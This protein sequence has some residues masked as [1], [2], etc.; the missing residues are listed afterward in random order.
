MK[1]N[2]FSLNII[3]Y[4]PIKHQLS[5][6]S[7]LKLPT[8]SC[9]PQKLTSSLPKHDIFIR[10]YSSEKLRTLKGYGLRRT[11]CYKTI[12]INPP[13]PSFTIFVSDNCNF[14]RAF[15]GIR[16]ILA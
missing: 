7:S 3:Q 11:L 5:E 14:S 15:S 8:N 2:P 12:A 13:W 16:A 4:I 6:Y 10:L 1:N 9:K